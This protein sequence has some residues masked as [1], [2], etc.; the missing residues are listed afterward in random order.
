MSLMNNIVDSGAEK[1][2]ADYCFTIFN[3]A[4]VEIKTHY[5]KN[6]VAICTDNDGEDEGAE[7]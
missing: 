7:K 1:K 3:E 2:T 6:V 5:G 4:I